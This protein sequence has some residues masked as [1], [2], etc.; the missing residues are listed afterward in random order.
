MALE[1]VKQDL[2]EAAMFTAKR[3][4]IQWAEVFYK[5]PVLALRGTFYPITNATIDVLEK[6]LGEFAQSPLVAGET[7]VALLEMTLRRLNT[8]EFI[9][10]KDFLERADMLAGLGRPVL[11]SNFL[12]YHRLVRYLA[13]YTQRPIALAM[14]ASKLREIFDVS[15]YNVSE[16]GILGGLGELFKNPGRLYVHPS[17]DNKTGALLTAENFAAPAGLEHLY[18]YLRENGFI[19]GLQQYN[20]EVLRIRSEDILNR[21]KTG[22]PSW[23][24]LVP[25]PVVEIIKR[26]G[27]CGSGVETRR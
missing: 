22:D 25:P 3:E 4:P 1:L 27:L 2:T 10:E 19:E 24:G 14:G 13:G 15:L 11:I 23:Q 21:I 9:D 16:G 7:P 17:L 6:A 18:A 12:R 26:D 8:G 20:P 5:K